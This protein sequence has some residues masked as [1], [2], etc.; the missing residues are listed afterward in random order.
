MTLED[1]H[2]IHDVVMGMAVVFDLCLMLGHNLRELGKII[3]FVLCF[4]LQR[5]PHCQGEGQCEA[6]K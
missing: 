6:Q 3:R 5:N 2:Y 1:V 4:R